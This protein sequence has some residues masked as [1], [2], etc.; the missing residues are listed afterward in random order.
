MTT[1]LPGQCFPCRPHSDSA[2]ATDRTGCCLH[3]PTSQSFGCLAPR[4][5][6]LRPV[7]PRCRFAGRRPNSAVQP[8]TS[9]ISGSSVRNSAARKRRGRRDP[10]SNTHRS[11]NFGHGVAHHTRPPSTAN[12]HRRTIS[13]RSSTGGVGCQR[14]GT[15]R[16]RHNVTRYATRWP[17][18]RSYASR[19]LWRSRPSPVEPTPNSP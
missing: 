6:H 17:P 1:S 13:D 10:V 9:S 18:W 15:P 14:V 19:H 3:S 8:R 16:C 7:R 11:T 5:A 12:R 4:C 2:P